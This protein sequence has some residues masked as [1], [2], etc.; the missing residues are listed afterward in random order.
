MKTTLSLRVVPN[1]KRTSCEGLMDD[2]SS[3]RVKLAAPPLDGKANVA[4]IKWLAQTLKIRSTDIQIVS[5]QTSRQKT[6]EIEGLTPSDVLPLLIRECKSANSPDKKSR[7]SH[8]IH[9]DNV[10]SPPRGSN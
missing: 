4:L 1:A 2:G 7:K 5:G 6:I 3:L 10:S 9:P 8:K